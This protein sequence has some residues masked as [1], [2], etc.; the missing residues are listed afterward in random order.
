MVITPPRDETRDKQGDVFNL[1]LR[2]RSTRTKG[3]KD[4]AHLVH[5][6]RVPA[7][8]PTPGGGACW[9]VLC[10]RRGRL[11][12]RQLAVAAISRAP[13]PV[14][15]TNRI[16]GAAVHGIAARL[17]CHEC[18]N[19]MYGNLWL[20]DRAKTADGEVIKM[21]GYA[22]VK[23]ASQPGKLTVHLDGVPFDA[24][25]WILALGGEEE[26]SRRILS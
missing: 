16:S 13:I 19:L 20:R 1:T 15:R 26:V 24:P 25:Y 18:V 23:D 7:P 10:S 4:V 22:Y 2:M 8:A 3:G 21:D 11:P 14:A 6:N 9:R 5:V 12:E 17:A